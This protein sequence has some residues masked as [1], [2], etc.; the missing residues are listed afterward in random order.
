MVFQDVHELSMNRTEQQLEAQGVEQ[1]DLATLIKHREWVQADARLADVYHQFD[2]HDYDSCAVMEGGKVLGICFRG[3]L[4]FLMGHRYGYA[5][6]SRQS[7]HL[8][9]SANPMF[10]H[11]GTPLLE[12]LERV[13][14]RQG[15]AFNEDV[16]LLGADNEYLGIIAVPSL[17]QLQS[18]LVTEKFR[19]QEALNCQLLTVSRQAGMAE[20]ASSVLHNVGNVLNS[21]KVSA[22][23]IA[24]KL[25][26]SKTTSVIRVSNLLRDNANNL[27]H[28][29]TNDERG[30]KLP[31]YLEQLGQVLEVDR[32]ELRK[33][34]DS[35]TE[36][37]GH[38]ERVIFTQQQYA[39]ISAVV[40]NVSIVNLIEDAMKINAEAYSRHCIAIR[41]EF[42]TIPEV[43]LD[44]HK[45]L[46]ILV[47][48]LS[49]AKYAC[50]SKEKPGREVVLRL[51]LG[52][53]DR[54]KIEVADNGVGI[55]P[56]NR[57]RIFSHGFT[58]RKTGHGFGLHN[59]ALAAKEMGGSLSVHSDGPGCGATFTL[60]IPLIA[61]MRNEKN[62]WANSPKSSPSNPAVSRHDST[63]RELALATE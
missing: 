11:H 28:F 25:R 51:K 58:T 55:S 14:S 56:E 2:K 39:N 34:V 48:L 63:T 22:S 45:V 36:Y 41:R 16:V 3:R 17:V 52:G 49:N 21:V 19:S 29:I 12:V 57:H 59:G 7:A 54:I 60:E 6:Y 32:A 13:L 38:I 53:Q 44:K 20:V 1:T 35:L 24:E 9:M 31:I 40:E 37:I 4:G 15:K 30:S 61:A 18:A 10:I 33:E 42:E 23:V 43:V 5:I 62:R 8:H 27:A 47:N 26:I 46:Q 50:Q